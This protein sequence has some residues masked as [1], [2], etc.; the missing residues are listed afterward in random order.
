MK[1]KACGY[2]LWN[3]APRQCP[4]CGTGFAPSQF[5]FLPNAVR[6]CCPHCAQ[7][8]Y[9]TS[10]DGHLQPRA[11]ACVRCGRDIDEDQMIL[12]PAAGVAEEDAAVDDAPW[13]R[14]DRGWLRALGQTTWRVLFTPHRLARSLRDRGRLSDAVRYMLW[15]SGTCALLMAI[16]VAVMFGLFGLLAGLGTGGAGGAQGFF[17]GVPARVLAPTTLLWFGVPLALLVLISLWGLTSHGLLRL[18]ARPAGTLRETL[19]CFYYASVAIPISTI[20]ICF[21]PIGGLG[22]LWTTGSASAMVAVRQRVRWW[23]ALIAVAGPVLLA[24]GSAVAAVVLAVWTGMQAAS[25]VAPVVIPPQVPPPPAMTAPAPE[26]AAA[27]PVVPEPAAPE[28]SAPPR[29]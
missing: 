29:G 20:P 24:G 3:L 9:G 11:F 7:S 25:G 13:L 16:F 1:C 2:A 26:P 12:L 27:E 21:W 19:E 18:M 17:A 23:I 6:F 4:E 22:V 10:A 5:Q 8:Y 15:T 28:P 14:R